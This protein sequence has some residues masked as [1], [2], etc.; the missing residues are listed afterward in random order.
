MAGYSSASFGIRAEELATPWRWKAPDLRGVRSAAPN[1]GCSQAASYGAGWPAQLEQAGTDDRAGGSSSV[2]SLALHA[3]SPVGALCFGV[4][5][6]S[7]VGGG[8]TATGCR[9]LRRGAP[10]LRFRPGWLAGWPGTASIR[11]PLIA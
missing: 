10:L 11:S 3:R 7:A 1:P 4:I 2:A 6:R 5:P 9:R 8:S